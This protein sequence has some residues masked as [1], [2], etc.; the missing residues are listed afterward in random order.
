MQYFLFT[1][2]IAITS[3]LKTEGNASAKMDFKN[4][5]LTYRDKTTNLIKDTTALVIAEVRQRSGNFNFLYPKAGDFQCLITLTKL[6]NNQTGV[7]IKF[8]AT[9]T[10]TEFIEN[11]FVNQKKRVQNV[12]LE[13]AGIFEQKLKSFIE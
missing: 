13:S 10:M 3:Q 7:I 2:N 4:V 1:E 6:P 5:K 12:R 9:C 8:D 11:S